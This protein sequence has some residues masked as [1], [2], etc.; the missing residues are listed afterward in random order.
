MNVTK[1]SGDYCTNI[2][3]N[4]LKYSGEYPQIFWGIS[5]NTLENVAKHSG[6]C[7]QTYQGISPNIWGN[8]VK[9]C[10]EY[11]QTFCRMLQNIPGNIL[12]LTFLVCLKKIGCWVNPRFH[13]VIFVFGV[14]K[15]Q[16]AG[17]VQDFLG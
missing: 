3:G 10:G 6:Q 11:P 8:V 1:L 7:P 13:V 2:P 16:E 12:K 4:V 5:S 9:H 17:G 14:N 15:K